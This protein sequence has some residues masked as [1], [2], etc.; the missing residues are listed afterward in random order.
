VLIVV[1]SI[2]GLALV[3]LGMSLCR[4]A[5]KSD[6][7]DAE[8]VANWLGTYQVQDAPPLDDEDVLELQRTRATR[9]L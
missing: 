2:A 7:A 1:I 5:A 8:S 9:G 4:L 3:A 6:E